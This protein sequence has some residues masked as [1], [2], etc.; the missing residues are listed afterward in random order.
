MPIE[1]GR[2]RSSALVALAMSVSIAPTAA[3]A[4]SGSHSKYRPGLT[5]SSAGGASMDRYKHLGSRPLR[6]GLAGQDVR[7]AQDYLRRAGFRARVDGQFGSGT[8]ELVKRFEG[9]NGLKADGRLSLSDIALLR[10]FVERGKAAARVRGVRA[11]QATADTAGLNADGTATPPSNA[12][13]AVK[14]IIAA[15]NA[16]AT[17]P[18][19]YGGGHGKWEDSGYDC[20]GSV[21]YALHGADL[22]DAPMASGGF[23]SWA[24]AGPGQWVTVYANGGHMYMVVA[25]LRFDTSGRSKT[26]SRWQTQL[27]PTSGYSVRHPAGL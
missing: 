25:G 5:S 4:H 3:S 21:S 11:T 2:L 18:Y 16:I 1:V 22:L 15:G 10:G 26:G 7:V 19:V 27:R 6:R 12:P 17:K 23:T 14:Q 20:S 8:A 9:A 13:D 24:D